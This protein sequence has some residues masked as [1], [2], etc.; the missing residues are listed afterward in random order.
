MY[1]LETNK[2]GFWFSLLYNLDAC[3]RDK[4]L[5]LELSLVGWGIY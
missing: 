3:M 2:E 1:I 4:S 5:D